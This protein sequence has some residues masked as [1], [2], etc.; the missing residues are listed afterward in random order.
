[1]IIE[2]HNVCQHCALINNT[3][4]KRVSPVWVL[5][6]LKGEAFDRFKAEVDNQFS[7]FS[8]TELQGYI[9]VAQHKWWNVTSIYDNL[10]DQW[11]KQ[12]GVPNNIPA[13]N[14]LALFNGANVEVIYHSPL[15]DFGKELRSIEI[16]KKDP[17]FL[18]TF[19]NRL[20]YSIVS[21][22]KEESA[23]TTFVDEI[24]DLEKL[25]KGLFDA[26]F[27][28]SDSSQCALN[29]TGYVSLNDEDY[30]SLSVELVFATALMKLIPSSVS[31]Q[32]NRLF[33]TAGVF[34]FV[35]EPDAYKCNKAFKLSVALMDAFC[36]NESDSEWFSQNDAASTFENSSIKKNLHWRSVYEQMNTDFNEEKLDSVYAKPHISPWAML[37]Y[38]LRPEYFRKYLR[39]LLRTVYEKIHDFGAL[40][41]MRYKTFVDRRF[42]QLLEGTAPVEN[43]SQFA[44]STI[45][46][47]LS[48]LWTPDN[49]GA[50]GLKQA[51][52][53]LSMLRDYLGRQREEV[54]RVKNWNQPNDKKYISF[55]QANDYPLKE[56]F[57]ERNKQFVSHYEEEATNHP[58]PNDNT[59]EIN[60]NREH[61]ELTDLH[62]IMQFHPMPLNLFVKA[63]LLA[64]LLPITVWVILKMIPDAV[65][66]SDFLE[67]GTGLTIMYIAV[68][69][70]VIL[71]AFGKYA[72]LTLRNIKNK[73][74][75]YI[76]WYYYQIERR[77]YLMTIER[78][79]EYYDELLAECDCV[80]TQLDSFIKADFPTFASFERY[81]QSKFQNNILGSLDNGKTILKSAAL[82]TELKIG[83]TEYALDVLTPGLFKALIESCDRSMCETIM[84]ML[85]KE[86]DTMSNSKNELMKHWSHLMADNM[87]I[88]VNSQNC[89]SD[90]S[91]PAF[92]SGANDSNNFLF[93]SIGA[94]C[95]TL[96][97]SVFVPVVP[98]YN[99][100]TAFVSNL[101]GA[102]LKWENLFTG[103]VSMRMPNYA[104]GGTNGWFE[105]GKI[106]LFIRMHSFQSL[107]REEGDTL[108]TIFN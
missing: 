84:M 52:L 51:T 3:T 98:S 88:Y 106:A 12:T 35:F 92:T 75:K 85:Q 71:C 60:K 56:I 44:R 99:W 27:F 49:K 107:C 16:L 43:G 19:A 55:P 81:H 108:K 9:D 8:E 47:F 104:Q 87:N 54:E 4:M 78:E 76:A 31:N 65:L 1:M 63:G 18:K 50:K 66:K 30:M 53:L 58:S 73:I 25:S 20:F 23:S 24:R 93:E 48:S 102:G 100:T 17:L 14:N 64:A 33:H 36:N 10:S 13:F 96:Y 67:S 101:G 89:N 40:T 80:K 97:P 11:N 90:I 79:L 95:A 69:V 61:N 5:T 34:N 45:S 103:G 94:V 29:N 38:K 32:Q 62:E 15:S 28:H 105:P 70:I 72:I 41:L 82:R 77:T 46:G 37:A 2:G 57:D 39:S 68:A 59:P 86:V 74:R 21:F 42:E 7:V 83:S 91:I 22:R 6:T 26:V